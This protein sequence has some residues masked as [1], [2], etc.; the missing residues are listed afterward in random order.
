VDCEF[1]ISV[2]VG[3][4]I[5]GPCSGRCSGAPVLAADGLELIGFNFSNSVDNRTIVECDRQA[6]GRRPDVEATRAHPSDI[7]DYFLTKQ[8]IESK[9]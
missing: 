4:T 3:T 7:L 6:R 8:E 2:F 9:G 1:K 5:P